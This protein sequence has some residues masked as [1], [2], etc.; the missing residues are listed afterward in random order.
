MGGDEFSVITTEA[1][2]DV[3]ERLLRM[4]QMAA[5]WKGQFINGISISYGVATA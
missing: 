3:T 1:E 5:S 2:K 4:E